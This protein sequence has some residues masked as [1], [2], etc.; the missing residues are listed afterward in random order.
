[1]S[2]TKPVE[3][4]FYGLVADLGQLQ[5]NLLKIKRTYPS[6]EHDVRYRCILAM[7]NQIKGEYEQKN[8]KFEQQQKCTIDGCREEGN[9]LGYTTEF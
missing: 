1:M 3:L 4:S 8:R 7:V 9:G 6:L 2:E 5:T